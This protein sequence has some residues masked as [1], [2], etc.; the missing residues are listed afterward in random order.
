MEATMLLKESEEPNVPKTKPS[1]RLELP[2]S[3]DEETVGPEVENDGLDF[4]DAPPPDLKG[5]DGTSFSIGDHPI[6]IE[7]PTLLEILSDKVSTQATR[8]RTT[9]PSTQHVQMD[10]PLAPRASEWDMW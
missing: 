3:S 4:L 5:I 9:T 8:R 2:D 1:Q 7:S 6:D 10:I